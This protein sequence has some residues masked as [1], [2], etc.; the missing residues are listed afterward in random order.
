M[1]VFNRELYP[2]LMLPEDIPESPDTTTATVLRFNADGQRAFSK[3]VLE[4]IGAV[5]Y[6]TRV[7]DYDPDIFNPSET[8]SRRDI[9][10]Q[11]VKIFS[12][13]APMRPIEELTPEEMHRS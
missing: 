12:H 1:I 13:N 2:G 7:V 5:V 6:A 10:D 4:H 8:Y 9:L 3:F 11:N